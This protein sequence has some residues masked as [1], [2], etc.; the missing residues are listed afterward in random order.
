MMLMLTPSCLQRVKILF[1]K[2]DTA[3]IQLAEAQQASLA[4]NHLDKT[5]L[6]GKVIRV[7]LSKHSNVQVRSFHTAHHSDLIPTYFSCQRTVSPTL[8]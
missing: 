6:W 2:K 1:N 5:K 3:L 8:V 4:I 7:M